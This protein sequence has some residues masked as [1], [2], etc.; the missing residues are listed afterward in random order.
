MHTLI[1]RNR[2]PSPVSDRS[3]S[4]ACKFPSSST[5]VSGKEVDTPS[6]SAQT[7]TPVVHIV[8]LAVSPDVRDP[9]LHTSV[10]TPSDNFSER[11]ENTGHRAIV[12]SRRCFTVLYALTYCQ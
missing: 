7:A 8:L 3:A 10:L 2:L 12:H 1:G 5:V 4:I 6:S 9:L 11:D